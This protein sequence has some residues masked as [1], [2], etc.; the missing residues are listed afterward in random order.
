MPSKR[1]I[2]LVLLLAM[3]FGGIG[4]GA[5]GL[6]VAVV[7]IV[8]SLTV[9]LEE[10]YRGD[11]RILSVLDAR[12]IQYHDDVKLVGMVRSLA[13]KLDIPPPRVFEVEDDL[14]N[15]FALGRSPEHG[16][17]VFTGQVQHLLSEGELE[18]VIGHEL[19]HL[20][21]RDTCSRAAA[22]TL[23]G[24]LAA[25]STILGLI[26]L[27]LRRNGGAF[28][29]LVPIATSLAGGVVRMLVAHGQEY[30]ADRIGAELAGSPEFMISALRKLE[31]ATSY[32]GSLAVAAKPALAFSLLMQPVGDGWRLPSHP[33]IAKRIAR[34]RRFQRPPLL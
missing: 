8:A 2:F 24:A 30:A 15:A 28:M 5:F 1:T 17:L 19:A 34:L 11:R 13:A 26:G 4:Y 25:L 27:G 7:A 9:Q 20:Y 6:G 3:L 31:A 12:E 16:S 29:I 32:G 23:F 18:S 14:P 33:P 10:L 22:S 21:H